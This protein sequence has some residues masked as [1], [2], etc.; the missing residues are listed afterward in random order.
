M[1]KKLSKRQNQII[2][3]STKIIHTKGIQGLT[4]K[5]ISAAIEVTEA[6]IY[7]HFKSKEEILST[8]L[9]DFRLNL[10]D[11]VQ[12][13]LKSDFSALVKLKTIKDLAIFNGTRE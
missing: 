13:I 4:I 1:S 10:N 2:K 7:R 11:K 5:N 9:D 12:S 3:E 6:A 8:I